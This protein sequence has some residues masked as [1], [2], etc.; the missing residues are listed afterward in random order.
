MSE[1]FHP[2]VFTNNWST[3]RWFNVTL[4]SGYLTILKGHLTIPKMPGSYNLLWPTRQVALPFA[5]RILRLR[6]MALD[7]HVAGM[8]EDE[9]WTRRYGSTLYLGCTWWI[10]LEVLRGKTFQSFTCQLTGY[11]AKGAM[12]LGWSPV[13]WGVKRRTLVVNK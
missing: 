9:E 11:H 5:K 13:C 10:I 12:V 8:D 4:S 6:C 1:K 3:T 7:A 2:N